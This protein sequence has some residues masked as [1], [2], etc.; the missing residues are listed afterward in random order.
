MS[1]ERLP[2][3][4]DVGEHR[5]ELA[6]WIRSNRGWLE[7]ELASAGA[8]VLK[9]A[10]VATPEAFE[11]AVS[12]ISTEIYTQNGEHVAFN[13]TG[14][15]QTPVFYPPESKILWHNENS[16]HHSWPA[17]LF[18]SCISPSAEGGE[19]PL[20][21]SRLVYRRLSRSVRE[22][23]EQRGVRYVRNYVQGFGLTYE[24]TLNVMGREE[25]ETFCQSNFMDYLWRDDILCT[26]AARPATIEHP[27]TG[28]TSFIAQGLHWHQACLPADIRES[29]REFYG[30]DLMPRDF[31]FGDG[32]R[33]EDAI[34]DELLAIYG[35]L[36][37]AR[38][39]EAGEI[40]VI[41]NMITAHARNPYVGKRLM[42]VALADPVKFRDSDNQQRA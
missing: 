31:L 33:I 8:L 20:V 28:E 26:S 21:D 15:V 39:W 40:V 29:M 42:L 11:S 24:K 23:F 1:N 12:A 22:A 37:Y 19:T 7:S 2:T 41:D 9:G 3:I 10:N 4:I 6:G 17:R 5:P 25:A 13:A 30:E 32:G 27:K 16:F 18:F 36:E 34:I 14:T 35:E 38:P